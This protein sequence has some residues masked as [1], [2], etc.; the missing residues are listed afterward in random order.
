M[1]IDLCIY[2][3]MYTRG[4]KGGEVGDRGEGRARPRPRERPKRPAIHCLG[5]EDGYIV[6]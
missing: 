6:M 5:R 4:G 1:C 3:Y 2:L